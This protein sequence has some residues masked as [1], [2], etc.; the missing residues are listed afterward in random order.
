[1]ILKNTKYR[2]L[3]LSFLDFKYKMV[4]HMALAAVHF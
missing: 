3:D 4:T 2:V 1:M